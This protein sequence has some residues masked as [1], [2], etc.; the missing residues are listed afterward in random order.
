MAVGSRQLPLKVTNTRTRT[1]AHRHVGATVKD[2]T[3]ED[4]QMIKR[5]VKPGPPHHLYLYRT[6]R[7]GCCATRVL[8]LEPLCKPLRSIRST[9]ARRSQRAIR[10]IGRWDN[11]LKAKLSQ[12]MAHLAVVTPGEAK[13]PA[14]LEKQVGTAHHGLL[15]GML[16]LRVGSPDNQQA[17]ISQKPTNC[18]R[19]EGSQH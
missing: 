15:S 17:Q 7:K 19:K 9:S 18:A 6:V 8:V 2:S 10:R 14:L 4:N 16:I 13:E 1:N 11:L 3:M 5:R 12:D